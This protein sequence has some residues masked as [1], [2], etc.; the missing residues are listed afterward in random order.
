MRGGSMLA[1]N[2]LP[3]EVI[4]ILSA[5]IRRLRRGAW[6]ML[7]A[8]AI[9]EA[10]AGVVL[11]P[12]GAAAVNG[13][14]RRSGRYAVANEDLV[15][16]VLSPLGAAT[17]FV[18][19]T[20]G[21]TVAGLGRAAALHALRGAECGGGVSG[22]LAFARALA[23]LAQIME[24]AV[25]QVCILGL[26]ALPFGAVV[27]VIV[28]MTFR[29]VDLYWMV[30]VRP[31]RFWVGVGLAAPVALWG[32]W[33]IGRRA[34]MWSIALPLCVLCGRPAGAALRESAAHLS[35]RLRGVAVVRLMW[36]GAASAIGAGALAI[37]QAAAE[38]L[39]ERELGGVTVTA[40][41]A[42]A[43]LMMYVGVGFVVSLIASAG[44]IAAVYAAWGRYS[45]G[46][47]AAALRVDVSRHARGARRTR[48]TVFACLVV[49]AAAAGVG[50]VRLL[51]SARAPV[52][53]EV[54]AHRGAA[55][56][57]PENTLA[58]IRAAIALGVDRVEFDVMRSADGALVLFHDTDLRRIARD[59]RRIASLTLEEL[60]AVDVGSWFGPEFA[61]EGIPT[62]EEAL[63]VARGRVRVNVELKAAGDEEELAERVAAVMRV[64]DVSGAEGAVLTSLSTRT[65]AVVRRVDP[66]ARIGLIVTASMGELRRVDVDFLVVESGIATE[67][68]LRRAA[69]AGLPV[70]VW[71]VTDPDDFA[72]L[73]L[74]GVEG[75]ISSDPGA[76][77]ARRGELMQLKEV[78]RLLLAFRVRVLGRSARAVPEAGADASGV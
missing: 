58:A 29:G 45:P 49:G 54:T 7:V 38:R 28:W 60:R 66:G 70:H 48:L 67:R 18:S 12:L 41:A 17:L 65:L 72:R 27:G 6:P 53:I 36:L 9:A 68:F 59:P 61:G 46:G 37:V 52:V 76:L 40:I 20:V 69:R 62:L 51:E 26:I 44:D 19:V 34:L 25:R 8:L 11:A 31:V 42:G 3:L 39:L 55:R 75:V 4:T 22:V 16:F 50:A 15:G 1:L 33:R 64:H 24:L 23:R 2:T 14:I 21:L 56:E 35:G 43:A 10:V 13:L 47:E 5:A 73:M 57:A 32:V 71:G 77:L 78:E 30:T 63:E 74:Q